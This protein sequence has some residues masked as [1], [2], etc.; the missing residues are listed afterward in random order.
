MTRCAAAFFVSI[1]VAATAGAQMPDIS[2][3]SGV[4]LPTG[5]LPAGTVSVRVVRGD[6]SN[7]VPGHPVELHVGSSV[8]T[9]NT[10]SEGRAQF[11]GVA[12]GASAHAM[13]TIDGQR[14]ESREFTVPQDGGIRLVLGAGAPAGGAS[15]AA[16]AAGTAAPPAAASPSIPLAPGT[17]MFGGQSRVVAE[18]SD[19]ALDVYF[20][21]DVVN[22]GSGPVTVEPLVFEVPRSATG[23][24]VLENS[25]PQAKV[26]GKRV[27]VEGPFAPGVTNVQFAYQLPVSSARLQFSQRFPAAFAPASVIVQKY[28]EMHFGSPQVG[29]HHETSNNGRTYIVASGPGL[30]AG[31]TLDLEVTGLPYHARWPRYLALALAALVLGG[32]AWLSMGDARTET[33]ARRQSLEGRRE[34]LLGELV[35]IEEQRLAGRADEAKSQARREHLL[36]QLEQ[37]YAQLERAGT[38]LGAPPASDDRAGARAGA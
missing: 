14:L 12:I 25:S 20:L 35:K 21:L 4:P 32:G 22:P 16:P 6:L 10:D 36:D 11:S 33:E 5:D 30:K 28:G 1:A 15:A 29:D 8:V 23:T 2:A 37:V 31:E 3:M 19:D 24:T 38:V 18:L 13:T 27:I 34:Q 17:V 26:D 9:Q 7:N